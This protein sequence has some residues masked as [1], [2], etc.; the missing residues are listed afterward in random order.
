LRDARHL[1]GKEVAQ[2]H[3]GIQKDLN[4]RR[5]R[6]AVI[7]P[8]GERLVRFACI[9]H[10]ISHVAG[11]TGLGA[12]MGSKKLKAFAVKGKTVPAVANPGTV[13]DLSRWMAKNFREKTIL[14]KF[15]TGAVIESFNLAGNLS[16]RNFQE[17]FFEGVEN[18]AAKGICEPFGA[19]SG[20]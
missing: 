7:G 16:V 2:T 8:A 9:L 15:G 19:F 3:F 13:R 12:V 5:I 14:W 6:T 10:E 4:D 17:G 11:R 1:W 20:G 18:L